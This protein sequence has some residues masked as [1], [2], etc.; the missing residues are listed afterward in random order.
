M[1]LLVNQSKSCLRGSGIFSPH[2]PIF[3]SGRYMTARILKKVCSVLPEALIKRLSKLRSSSNA[4]EYFK[5]KSVVIVGPAS[6]IDETVLSRIK[7]ADM[8]IVINKGYR[9][10]S[11]E[12]IR[13]L[14]KKT[15]IFHCLDQNEQ[16]GGG[17]ID[18]WELSQKGFQ[19]VFYPL[20]DDRFQEN[21]EMFH[22]ENRSLLKLVQVDKSFFNDVKCAIGGF[23]PNTGAA[24][25]YI[26]SAAPG[27]KVYVHGITFFRTA[28]LEEYAPHLE[29]LFG[30]IK[31]I[32]AYGNHNPDLEF[33]YFRSL[34][35]KRNI[36]VSDD[37]RKI[38]DQPYVPLFY[39]SKKEAGHPQ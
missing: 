2:S 29:S 19:T 17:R 25:I 35:M 28:Y 33:L 9:L 13:K 7:A 31:M 12:L 10:K 30:T 27:A 1:R 37:L 32:E 23:T 36:E 8:C 24:A 20:N 15:V 22:K 16:T 39:T 38:I 18:S 5:N 34:V 14:A 21:I 26:T 3:D 4:K 6:E 11:F